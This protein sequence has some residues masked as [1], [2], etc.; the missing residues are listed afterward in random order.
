MTLARRRDTGSQARP[1][2][3][4]VHEQ[5]GYLTAADGRALYVHVVLP[6]SHIQIGQP[7]QI[8]MPDAEERTWCLTVMVRLAR[9]LARRGHPVFRADYR[10]QGESD[11]RYEETD[12][13]TR[14]E[15]IRTLAR[16][17][18][19]ATGSPPIIFGARLGANLAARVAAS[20][21]DLCR[22]L[23]ALA[24]CSSG[25]AYA[26][27]LLRR[28]VASQMA[29]HKKVVEPMSSIRERCAAGDLIGC[30]GFL[31]GARLLDSL[32]ELSWDADV[33]A[34][35]PLAV[36]ETR[37][38]RTTREEE[39]IPPIWKELSYYVTTPAPLIAGVGEAIAASGPQHRNLSELPCEARARDGR[40]SI[41]VPAHDEHLAATF[42]PARGSQSG[43]GI[44]LVNPGPNDRAGPH[45]LYHRVAR[46][47]A[48]RG[49]PVLRIDGPGIGESSGTWP[50]YEG[51]RIDAFF[52]SLNGGML[53]P[54]LLPALREFA[55]RASGPIVVT[56]LCGG[57]STAVYLAAAAPECVRHAVLLGIP[58][59]HQG[60]GRDVVLPAQTVRDNF[61]VML[62]KTV[63]PKYWLRLLTA[64]SDVRT[65]L[66]VLRERAAQTLPA[67]SK[68]AKNRAHTPANLN[69]ELLDTWKQA[70]GEGVR[71]TFVFGEYDHLLEAMHDHR[72]HL[73]QRARDTENLETVVLHGTTHA[74][75][76]RDAERD[77]VSIL[78]H[79]SS[80]ATE[81]DP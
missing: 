20:S 34:A 64:K 36:L 7:L 63:Q 18:R 38:I 2:T 1:T 16:A 54:A 79:F 72:D 21:P 6:P 27:D 26:T 78:E 45:G 4:V 31:V 55:R 66:R 42:H 47:L 53:A 51:R 80:T 81:A 37:R 30:N 40:E 41:S 57:A 5:R 35:P 52:R 25:A 70:L 60:V 3:P 68:T 12:V 13:G 39:V 56:G 74:I 76:E 23:V 10:G 11:G 49:R 15:D 29:A 33:A 14:L 77:F 61:R 46:E 69:V 58:V 71:S 67:V 73:E 43:S 8:A 17:V 48:S 62:H 28:N 19:D 9:A 24:P 59:I 32:S 50:D 22:G 44:L 65:L 75:T